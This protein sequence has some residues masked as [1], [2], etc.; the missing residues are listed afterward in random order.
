MRTNQ[1]KII[2]RGDKKNKNEKAG[3]ALQQFINHKRVVI[4]LGI[5]CPIPM[6]NK[7]SQR[8][9]FKPE[10]DISRETVKRWNNIIIRS[11]DKANDLMYHYFMT[12]SLATEQQFKRDMADDSRLSSFVSF[13]EK[14]IPVL[15]NRWAP[16]T[17]RHYNVTLTALKEIA[18]DLR[19]GELTEQFLYRFEA[20]IKS[21][22]VG[23]N[24]LWRYHKDLRMFINEAIKSGMRLENP[25]QHFKLNKARGKRTWLTENEVIKLRDLYLS[26]K[27]HPSHEKLLRYFLFSCFTGLRIS[28][29]MRITYDDIIDGQLVFVPYKTKRYQKMCKVPLNE[30]AKFLAGTGTGKVK[31][32]ETFAEPVNNRYL[33]EIM[34]IAQIKKAVSFHCARHTFAMLFLEKGGKVEVLRDLLGHSDIQTTMTYVHDMN[35]A[36]KEQIMWMD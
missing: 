15:A 7:E 11:L 9:V 35:S 36:A 33:K 23:V 32:F 14:H 13:V 25:Y 10:F 18:P 22:G 8:V 12:N 16:G 26:H 27:L 1:P 19:Y 5:L 17:I 29:V 28:D 6:W 20:H 34:S 30:T 31:I 4:A 24:T 2:I 3:L 21:K